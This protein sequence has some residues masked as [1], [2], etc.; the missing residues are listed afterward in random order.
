[1]RCRAQTLVGGTL[2]CALSSHS[3]F[4]PVPL[5]PLLEVLNET[6]PPPGSTSAPR[7]AS[8]HIW[9][10]AESAQLPPWARPRSPAG[11]PE[12]A[13]HP[14]NEPTEPDSRIS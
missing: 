8:T 3:V 9:A 10:S 4:F 6:A 14:A 7:A 12:W 13:Q 2:C 1:M 11:V 5:Q